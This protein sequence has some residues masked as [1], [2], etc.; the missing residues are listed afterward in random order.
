MRIISGKARGLRLNA[1]VSEVARPTEDRVKETMFSCLGDLDGRTVLDLF[2]GTGGLG[3]EALSRGAAKVYMV[4]KDTKQAANL[5]S[6]F[7]ALLNVMPEAANNS[8]LITADVRNLP[9]LLPADAKGKIDLILADPPY[10]P[11]AGAFGAR[12]L[13]CFPELS[14]WLAPGCQLVLEHETGTALPW[15]PFS[16]W[17]LYRQKSFGIRTI[18]FAEIM[19]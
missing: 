7:E 19:P 2:S 18:S 13:L 16:K 5:Q 8:R 11:P 9:G 10:N 17:R 15:A 1:P 4:E 3:L 6:N 14:A 12:E